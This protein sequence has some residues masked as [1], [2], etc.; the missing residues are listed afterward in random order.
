MNKYENKDLIKAIIIEISNRK[1]YDKFTIAYYIGMMVGHAC[2]ICISPDYY[3]RDEIISNFSSLI[4]Q[5][6]K[7]KY[8]DNGHV[9]TNI[10]PNF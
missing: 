9:F 2:N 5:P 4:N 10:F 3:K 6:E 7:L 1:K 8:L